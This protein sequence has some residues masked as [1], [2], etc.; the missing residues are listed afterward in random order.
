MF[1]IRLQRRSIPLAFFEPLNVDQQNTDWL[2]DRLAFAAGRKLRTA[3]LRNAGTVALADPHFEGIELVLEE[4]GQQVRLRLVNRVEASLDDSSYRELLRRLL[5]IEL[6]RQLAYVERSVWFRSQGFYE[7]R[8]AGRLYQGHWIEGWRTE[9]IIRR[10]EVLLAVDRKLLPLGPHLGSR[11]I[12]DWA[13]FIRHNPYAAGLPDEEGK[14]FD[15]VYTSLPAFT[16]RRR[17]YVLQ[18]DSGHLRRVYVNVDRT[19]SDK[20][21]RIWVE[22]LK[23][24]YDE[25]MTK[26]AP[27]SLFPILAPHEA[28]KYLG[29][30]WRNQMNASPEK[31]R[32]SARRFVSSHLQNLALFGSKTTVEPN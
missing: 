26:V 23:D 9:I 11:Y 16:E 22:P 5:S 32:E 4:G 15:S 3:A 1:T 30:Q 27:G 19:C 14:G 6:K 18:D 8:F 29:Y 21:D 10:G 25:Q 17:N 13:E 24:A 20:G 28:Q 7:H 2:L 12:S 31:R